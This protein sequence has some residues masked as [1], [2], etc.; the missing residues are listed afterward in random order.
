MLCAEIIREPRTAAVITIHPSPFRRPE[1]SFD[2]SVTGGPRRTRQANRF[3]DRAHERVRISGTVVS[4]GSNRS[5]AN[6][7][8]VAV[9]NNGLAWMKFNVG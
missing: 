3:S 7:M 9:Q 1:K 2:F 4:R 5:F 8:K 6:S